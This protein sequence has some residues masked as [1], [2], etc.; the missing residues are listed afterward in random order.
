[1]EAYK[2][3]C[4]DCR[5]VRYWA[6][7]KTGLGKSVAQLEEMEKSRKTCVRCGSERA[8]TDLDHETEMGQVMD[9]QMNGLFQALI[10]AFGEESDAPKEGEIIGTDPEVAAKADEDYIETAEAERRIRTRFGLTR[11]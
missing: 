6:D 4:P 2:T 7:Y 9:A 5:H 8:I 1:M 11:K 10:L 3:T